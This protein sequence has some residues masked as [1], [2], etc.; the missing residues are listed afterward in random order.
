MK[1]KLALLALFAIAL[2]GC[3]G[4]ATESG[5]G[6]TLDATKPAETSTGG[7]STQTPAATPQLPEEMKSEAYHW[8]GLGN[9]KPMKIEVKTGP[10]TLTGTQTIHL[11]TVKAGAANFDIDRS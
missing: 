7:G 1:L 10:K 11:S 9:D 4:K 2:V 3:N 5:T 8:F 6:S